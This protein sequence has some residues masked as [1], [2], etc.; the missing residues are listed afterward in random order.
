MKIF[1]LGYNMIFFNFFQF[2]QNKIS[3]EI[4]GLFMCKIFYLKQEIFHG[5]DFDRS[6]G[7]VFM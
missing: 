7:R 2:I 5:F 6:G 1:L 3:M 4:N